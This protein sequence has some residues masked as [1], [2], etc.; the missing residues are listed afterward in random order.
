MSYPPTRP[1]S[2]APSLRQWRISRRLLLTLAAILALCSTLLV[3]AFSKA[4]D[5]NRLAGVQ[6][7]RPKLARL[8]ES[9][10]LSDRVSARASGRGSLTINLSDGRDVLTSYFGREDLRLALEQNRA[11]PL[12][13]ASAD[14]DEDGVPDL[15]SGYAYEGQGIVTLLRGNVDSIYPSTPEAQQRSASGTTTESPFLSQALFFAVLVAANFLGAGD[16]DGDG[17]SDVIAA[18]RSGSSLFL[19]SGDGH[20]SFTQAR[21]IALPGLVT[22]MALGDLN[23][24]DG[25]TDVIVGVNGTDGSKVMVFEGPEGALRSTPEVFIT[26]SAVASLVVAQLD[27]DQQA[28]L[29][30]AAGREL[31]VVSGRDRK[32]SLN[33]K[34][35]A[36]VKAAS[37]ARRTFAFGIRSIAT[38]EFTG[39]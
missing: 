9:A 22:A 14:F 13:L 25:L 10:R 33:D 15:V 20:G 28:D 34:S 31:L 18:S 26:R 12:S 3:G 38:G 4:N 29:A 21:E 7:E 6:Q 32:L 11:E 8:S 30:I 39:R 35:R 17:H 23:R 19:L 36:D 37:I 2:T 24:P 27:A 5:P 1:R 16:F